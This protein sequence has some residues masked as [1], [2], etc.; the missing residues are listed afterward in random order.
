MTA[1]RPRP[2]APGLFFL[3]LRWRLL[4][5]AFRAF[6]G[7]SPVRPVTILLCSLVVCAFVF[8]V[9][10]GGFKFFK[11]QEWPLSGGVV[12]LLFVLLFFSL[13]LLLVFSSGLI[14]YSSL[15]SSAE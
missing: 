13:A 14:L 11:G 5:N 1:P 8:A 3:R 10:L 4:R 2:A 6:R 9:S 12:S 15:F 7:Q